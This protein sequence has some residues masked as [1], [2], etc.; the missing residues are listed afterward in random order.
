[1]S[2]V[3]VSLS[4]A[5]RS[6]RHVG[7]TFRSMCLVG[8]SLVSM[9][10]RSMSLRSRSFG[11]LSVVSMSF[12]SMSLFGMCLSRRSMVSGVRMRRVV[13]VKANEQ[14]HQTHQ[15]QRPGEQ[16]HFGCEYKHVVVRFD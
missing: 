9:S 12:C 8:M 15:R 3:G 6:I 4:M 10:F 1:M 16:F 13:R 2:H 11:G 14:E 5:F 7:V